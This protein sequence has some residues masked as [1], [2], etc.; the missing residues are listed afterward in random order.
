M[1]NK[2]PVPFLQNHA[3]GPVVI[4]VAGFAAIV[5]GIHQ[6]V[7][8]VAPGYQGVIDTGGEALDRRGWV[9][10]GLGVAGI[11]GAAISVRRQRLA[12]LP[13]AVGGAV[14]VEAVRTIVLVASTLPYALYTETTYRSTGEPVMF[15]LGAEPFLLVAGGVLLVGAGIVGL[16]GQRERNGGD[17]VSSPSGAAA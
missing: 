13:V 15:V 9:L 4:A 5:V 1:K 7:L 10:A 6:G 11:A 2:G 8:H 17:E 3:L 16:R 12:V 14:L